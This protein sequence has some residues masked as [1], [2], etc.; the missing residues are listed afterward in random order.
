MGDHQG[1]LCAVTVGPFVGVDLKLCPIVY[2]AYIVLTD[3]KLVQTSVMSKGA[4]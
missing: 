1:R 3:V 2:I 4:R